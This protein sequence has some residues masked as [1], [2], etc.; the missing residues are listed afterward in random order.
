MFKSTNVINIFPVPVWAHLLERAD[1]ERLNQDLEALVARERAAS[2]HFQPG[3][4]W[5][6][7][8]DLQDEEDL[9]EFCSYV[10]AAADGVLASL[11]VAERELRVTGCW[12]N[13][14]PANG[15]PHGAHT[16]PNNYLSGV[17]YLKTPPGGNTIVFHDPKPQGNIIWPRYTEPNAYNSR[18]ANITV[19]PGTMILFP[20]WLSHSVPP[21]QG[22]EE[23]VSISFNVMFVEFDERI[24]K[25]RWDPSQPLVT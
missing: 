10:Q 5:Q 23:R 1:A 6:S 13:I 21:S 22:E 14:Q 4:H 20:A 17:Y 2:E 24:S 3:Q 9:T 11:A 19:Q 25:P 15:V 7:R 12:I 18:Q 16:H 8:N